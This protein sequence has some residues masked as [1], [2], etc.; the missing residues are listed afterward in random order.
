MHKK[1]LT[2]SKEEEEPPFLG[3]SVKHQYQQEV[4]HDA[5]THHPAEGGQK[6]VLDDGGD[7]LAG[8]LKCEFIK[9]N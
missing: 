5:F 4:E 9:I 3:E 6:E 7:C 1:Q 2:P 8:S